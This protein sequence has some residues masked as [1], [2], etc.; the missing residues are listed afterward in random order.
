MFQLLGCEAINLQIT[1]SA[2]DKHLRWALTQS[3]GEVK[4]ERRPNERGQTQ[5]KQCLLYH[6]HR[7]RRLGGSRHRTTSSSRNESQERPSSTA[8][9]D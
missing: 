3:G 1:K 9:I 4:R 7:H 2:N 6:L 8:D 5:L